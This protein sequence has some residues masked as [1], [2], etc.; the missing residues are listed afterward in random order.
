MDRGCRRHVT[1]VTNKDPLNSAGDAAQPSVM[2]SVSLSRGSTASQTLLSSCS[3]LQ[4]VEAALLRALGWGSSRT[5]RTHSPNS[6][7][8]WAGDGQHQ[9]P[10]RW[11]RRIPAGSRSRWGCLP[12]AGRSR[13]PV[14]S[15]ESASGGHSTQARTRTRGGHHAGG[16]QDGQPTPRCPLASRG[17]GHCTR[18]HAS[19]KTISQPESV[20]RN[21]ENE[22]MKAE[23]D[24][25]RRHSSGNRE[26]DARLRGGCVHLHSS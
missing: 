20:T 3:N 10:G 8:A 22:A 1:Q 16:L 15:L 17:T 25:S 24:Q 19:R 4:E 11:R 13:S 23:E 5:L 9:R 6:P 14:A 7:T 12:G 21:R 2:I 26:G 18:T